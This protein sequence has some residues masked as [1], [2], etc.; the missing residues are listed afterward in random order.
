MMRMNLKL[1]ENLGTQTYSRE[2][3][4]CKW[5]SI[6]SDWIDEY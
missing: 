4:N 1:I 3:L 5:D 2:L 6:V